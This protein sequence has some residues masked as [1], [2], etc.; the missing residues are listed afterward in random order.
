MDLERKHMNDETHLGACQLW[1]IQEFATDL[2]SSNTTIQL[3]QF[4]PEAVCF[5][6]V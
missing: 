4:N 1:V 5:N 3:L 6:G 2:L